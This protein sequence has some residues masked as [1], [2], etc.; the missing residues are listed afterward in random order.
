MATLFIIEFGC[1]GASVNF[2][3]SR[4]RADEGDLRI[5]EPAMAGQRLHDFVGKSVDFAPRGA[6]ESFLK[7]FTYS[8]ANFEFTL[9][10]PLCAFVFSL[11]EIYTSTV[12][13]KI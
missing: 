8:A 1:R 6:A 7:A 13:R 11:R 2:L 10:R 12:P 5:R 3:F 9:I 4:A